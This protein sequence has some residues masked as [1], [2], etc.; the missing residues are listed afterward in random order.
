M[1]TSSPATNPYITVLTLV[2]TDTDNRSAWLHLVFALSHHFPAY[3]CWTPQ[4]QP[5][6]SDKPKTPVCAGAVGIHSHLGGIA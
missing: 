4:V 1:A 5:Q 6:D 3:A 2:D